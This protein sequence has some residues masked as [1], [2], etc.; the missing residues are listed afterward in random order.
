VFYYDKGRIITLG[1]YP[2]PGTLDHTHPGIITP[3]SEQN[4]CT[5]TSPGRNAK[6]QILHILIHG[7]AFIVY[8]TSKLS[9]ELN[10]VIDHY[11]AVVKVTER[12]SVSKGKM[13]RFDMDRWL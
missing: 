4:K 3:A 6:N 9:E 5:W 7:R 11:L 1:T 13:Q 8:S 12:P 10:I 2:R